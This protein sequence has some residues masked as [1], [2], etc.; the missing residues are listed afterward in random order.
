MAVAM[1]GHVH[2][3]AI[4]GGREIRAVV[5]VEA[6]QEELVR[7]AVAA[8]LR[9]DESRHHFHE[10]SGAKYRSQRELLLGDHAL[11]GRHRLAAQLAQLAGHHHFF[12]HGGGN[13][14]RAG[15]ARQQAGGGRREGSVPDLALRHGPYLI[16]DSSTTSNASWASASKVS[17]WPSP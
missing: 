17:S 12:E 9:D 10:L 6:A 1:R 5:E 15:H 3:H 16:S 14:A 2:R 11:A 8:V 13:A 4:D 7:L